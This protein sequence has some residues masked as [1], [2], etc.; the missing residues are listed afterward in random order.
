MN[1]TATI[2][3]GADED[4]LPLLEVRATSATEGDDGETVT[5]D[6]GVQAR[7]TLL[8]WRWTHANAN[9]AL[10]DLGWEIASAW[11]LVKDGGPRKW[12]ALAVPA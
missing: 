11:T 12:S 10:L 5:T 6:H 8:D 9:D 7:M 1:Y 4:A 3:A 2:T